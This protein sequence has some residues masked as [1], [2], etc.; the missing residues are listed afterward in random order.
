MAHEINQFLLIVHFLGLA[1]GLA[2]PFA[3]M[4]M[5]AVMAK[6]APAERP[7]L[8]RFPPAMTRIGDTGLALLWTSGPILL[9]H[10]WGGFGALPWTFHA[11]IT[12]VVLL[13]LVI[14]YAHSLQRKARQGDASAAARLPTVGKI[15]LALALTAIV[16][17]VL[18][19]H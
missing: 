8:A 14:G 2:V 15:A 16:F 9:F 19:F 18:T 10:K 5:M 6:A 11:K 3:N 13:T 4:T 12:A 7:V 1:M 17:A